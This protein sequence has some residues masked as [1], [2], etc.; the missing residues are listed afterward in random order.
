MKTS[1]SFIAIGIYLI[2]TGLVLDNPA[3][4]FG[5]C[6]SLAGLVMALQAIDTPSTMDGR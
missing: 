6:F 3:Q 5:I 4:F 2:I 1:I